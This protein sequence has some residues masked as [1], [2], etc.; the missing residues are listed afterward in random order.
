MSRAKMV[1]IISILV[2]ALFF[3]GFL[4]F[5]ST[6]NQVLDNHWQR[7][8]DVKYERAKIIRVVGEALERDPYLKDKYRGKQK[9]EVM[10]R[11]GEH[12]GEVHTIDNYL[13]N[14][15]N[16]HGKAGLDIIVGVDTAAPDNYLVSVYNYYRTPILYSMILFFLAISG[17]LAAKKG[18]NPL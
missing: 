16:V 4:Y 8:S 14:L 11:T 2:G 10:I 18:C 3:L 6:G 17:R 13:S 9:L 12:S 5:S 15:C 7:P 1:K